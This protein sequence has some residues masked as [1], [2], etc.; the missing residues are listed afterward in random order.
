MPWEKEIW[1]RRAS[2]AVLQLEDVALVGAPSHNRHA[3][4]IDSSSNVSGT[5]E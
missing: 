2:F 5:A 1:R 4:V 3:N